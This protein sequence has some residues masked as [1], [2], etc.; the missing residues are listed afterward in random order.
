MGTYI[1]KVIDNIIY[2]KISGEL[3]ANLVGDWLKAIEQEE[4]GSKQTLH[5]FNDIREINAVHLNF[6][7]LWGVAQQRLESYKSGDET[8]SA[9]W[10]STPLNHDISRMYQT[11]LEGTVYKVDVFYQLDEIVNFLSLEKDFLEKITFS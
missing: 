10:V 5:R 2:S 4:S 3:D 1:T 6:D 11:L 7:E 8:L 9:F